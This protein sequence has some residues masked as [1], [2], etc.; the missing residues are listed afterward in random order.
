M[1]TMTYDSIR[2]QKAKFARNVEY[3][4]ETAIDDVIDERVERA[5]SQ[6]VGE[7]VEELEEAASMLNKLSIDDE[8]MTE[9]TEVQR[10]LNAEENISF[11]EM[12][13]IE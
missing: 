5:H 3:I 4:K 2:E 9:S 1:L 7:T 10:L 8:V 11:N 6:Y 12:V 13:G